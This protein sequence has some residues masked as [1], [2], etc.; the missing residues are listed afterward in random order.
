[1]IR[2]VEEHGPY[3]V[4]AP[5]FALATPGPNESVLRTALSF[6]RLAEPIPFGK[7]GQRPGHAGHGPRPP[8][9][10]PLTSRRLAAL[11]GVLA[12]STSRREL[13][14]ASN[15]GR[16]PRRPRRRTNATSRGGR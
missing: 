10:P 16:G 4:I 3:I 9:T 14:T 2:T 15:T 8:Q 7:R 11:A 1:M 13:D 6:V 12:R 5:G